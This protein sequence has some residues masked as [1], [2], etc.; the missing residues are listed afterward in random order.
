[1]A[2]QHLV[3]ARAGASAPVQ[4]LD[5]QMQREALSRCVAK[6]TPSGAAV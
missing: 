4:H 3:R 6:E 2:A 5:P 1:M